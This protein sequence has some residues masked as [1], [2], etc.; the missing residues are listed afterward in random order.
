MRGDRHTGGEGRSDA[1]PVDVRPA[2]L[3]DVDP[4][5]DHGGPLVDLGAL[6]GGPGGDVIDVTPDDPPSD[7]RTAPRRRP[8]WIIA[9][10]VLILMLFVVASAPVGQPPL[11]RV[12]SMPPG[13]YLAYK[14]DS[15]RLYAL[16]L[17]GSHTWL[18]SYRVADGVRRWETELDLLPSDAIVESV[19]DT[20]LVSTREADPAGNRTVAVDGSSG[21]LLWTDPLPRA[22]FR[23]PGRQVLLAGYLS[24]G[25]SVE[26]AVPLRDA[27]GPGAPPV[28][29][30]AVDLPTGARVWTQR[31]AAGSWTAVPSD[32]DPG[33]QARVLVTVTADGQARSIDLGTGGVVADARIPLGGSR[34]WAPLTSV[35]SVALAGNLLLVGDRSGGDI[36]LTAYHADAL[37]PAWTVPYQM[38]DFV[39]APCAGLLCVAGADGVSVLDPATGASRWTIAILTLPDVV[40]GWLYALPFTAGSPIEPVLLEPSTGR[41]VL[42]LLNWHLVTGDNGPPYLLER[43]APGDTLW[44]GV[45]DVRS[46]RIRPLGTVPDT[47]GGECQA[48]QGYLTCQGHDGSLTVWRVH[49]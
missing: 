26:R 49:S 6:T 27:G 4:L 24:R 41:S 45:L 10:V 28:L 47:G 15:D 29:V 39:A 42:D 1:R 31:I 14:I 37:T 20:V 33:D 34:D 16:T 22:R 44:I 3:L 17:H 32:S 38:L 12:G 2:P 13:D 36:R 11:T 23:S 43:Y 46:P 35:T 40:G 19:G 9:V 21:R 18:V 7:S 48:G 30:T 25:G 8:R 5:V